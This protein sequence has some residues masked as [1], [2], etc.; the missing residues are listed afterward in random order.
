MRGSGLGA[1]ADAVTTGI[2][3]LARLSVV[4]DGAFAGVNWKKE[5][6]AAVMTIAASVAGKSESTVVY[7]RRLIGWVKLILIF[8]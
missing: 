8:L 5:H 1:V 2:G 7:K 6:P 4:V 3:A